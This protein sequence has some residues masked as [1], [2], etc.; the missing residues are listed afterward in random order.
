MS[1]NGYKD[2]AAAPVF[3]N[4][5]IFRKLLFYSLDIGAWLINLINGNDNFYSC[6]LCMVDSLD[7]LRHNAVISSYYQY[8]DICSVGASHT[9]GGEGLMSRSIQESNLLSVNRYHIGADMLSDASGLTVCYM[10][11]SDT[12]QKRGFTRTRAEDLI[13]ADA[14]RLSVF[15]RLFSFRSRFLIQRKRKRK[16]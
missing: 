8:G 6:S 5:L 12:V 9:H 14:V 3:R 13:R 4:Q 7:S 15:P 2:G 11:F 16:K 10:G 1:R